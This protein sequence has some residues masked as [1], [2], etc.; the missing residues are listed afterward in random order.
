MSAFVDGKW[1]ETTD[2]DAANLN[3]ASVPDRKSVV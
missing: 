3:S 1:A 2:V